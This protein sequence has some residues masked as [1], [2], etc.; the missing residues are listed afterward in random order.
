VVLLLLGDPNKKNYRE[1]N[2]FL[3]GCPDFFINSLQ[4]F[5]FPNTVFSA[6]KVL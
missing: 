6:P 5:F 1:N 3:S 4:T 2:V